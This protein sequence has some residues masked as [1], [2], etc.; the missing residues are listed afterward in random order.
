MTGVTLL[1]SGL[2][3]LLS[4]QIVR[5][6]KNFNNFRD[7][8]A[9]VFQTTINY[10][11]GKLNFIPNTEASTISEAVKSFFGDNGFAL[12][13]GTLG[14]TSTF[15]SYLTLSIVFSFLILLYSRQ[16][17]QALTQFCKESD[18]QT[19]LKMLKEIQNVGKQYLTGMLLL[20]SILGVLNS[21]GLLS[22][23]ID[24]AIFFGF[25]A[26]LLAIIPY[27]GS[28]A[29]GLIPTIYALI[30]YDS[31]WYPLGVIIIFWF[32]Q[33]IEGN[34]LNPKIVGGSLHINA[35]FSILS[36]IGGGLLWG[37][38]G[39]ILFLPLTAMLRTVSTYYIELKPLAILIGDGDDGQESQWWSKV[40]AKIVKNN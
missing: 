35:L 39:M 40:K 24:Y 32:V 16:L 29:G 22:L 9:V 12:V 1:L 11:N 7:E 33:F 14:F 28:F 26:A 27:I 23:G 5:M 25:L 38:P 37:I 30:T 31:Y 17:T 6:A 10:I 36:L 13:S 8:L 18:R 3:Y 4:A 19:F 20:I 21:I 15:L 34:F 2:I